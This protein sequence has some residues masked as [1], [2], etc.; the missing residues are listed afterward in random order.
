MKKREYIHAKIFPAP[1]ETL[2][3]FTG[4]FYYVVVCTHKRTNETTAWIYEDW[5]RARGHA[6]SRAN[7][8]RYRNYVY[9]V[10]EWF[11]KPSEFDFDDV[12]DKTT[13]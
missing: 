4:K 5:D 6:D 7:D 8:L 1:V 12:R 2:K 13:Y 9:T 3:D 10:E 11:T